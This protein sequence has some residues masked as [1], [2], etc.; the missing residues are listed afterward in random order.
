[1]ISAAIKYARRNA[2]LL[3]MA[4]AA[5]LSLAALCASVYAWRASEA[6]SER[7]LAAY[8][9]DLADSYADETIDRDRP[10]PPKP[11]K[12]PKHD[13]PGDGPPAPPPPH[14]HKGPH[15]LDPPHIKKFF[16]M[17]GTDIAVRSGGLILFDRSGEPLEIT[18]GAER[19]AVL[20]DRDAP[21]EGSFTAEVSGMRVQ[22]AIR[23]LEG[24]GWILAAASGANLFART[25]SIW[26]IAMMIAAA[27]S[28]AVFVCVALLHRLVAIPLRR[29]ADGI[30][31]A[32][33]GRTM[34]DVGDPWIREVRAVADVARIAGAD[35]IEK[36]EGR[37]RYVSDIVRVQEE[38][39]RRLARE[40]HDGPLQTAVAA[41]KRIQLATLAARD[42]DSVK[43]ALAEA[44]KISTAVVSEIREA[45]EVLSPAWSTLGIAAA[46]EETAARL[47]RAHGIVVDATVPD[48]ALDVSSEATLTIMRASSEAVSNAVRHGGASRVE[49]ELSVIDGALDFR[50][51]DDGRGLDAIP[52]SYQALRDQGHRGLSNIYERVVLLGGTM[53]ILRGS[54][55]LRGAELK[56]RMP[57]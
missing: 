32:D 44:E 8:V 16:G 14:D 13:R 42:D 19:F 55:D 1:M 6:S 20:F 54:G 25:Y 11:P 30:E 47:S 43:G 56:L 38:E 2:M 52:S 28:L 40:L 35:A 23:A 24:G 15:P 57:M 49:M 5:V 9:S 10:A 50:V 21:M 45:C 29:V 3:S 7:V 37:R 34:P 31:R 4:L 41:V 18:D 48:G 33:W 36:Q 51:R 53:E 39:S 17:F 46:L 27:A 22:A 26:R 12:P